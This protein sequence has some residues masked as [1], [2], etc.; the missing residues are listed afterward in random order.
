MLCV[1]FRVVVGGMKK[2][3]KKERKKE[4]EKTVCVALVAYTQTTSVAV[5]NCVSPAERERER[6]GEGEWTWTYGSV[7]Q[8]GKRRQT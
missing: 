5:I 7:R 3:R 6:D 1:S 2:E 8:V 4:E